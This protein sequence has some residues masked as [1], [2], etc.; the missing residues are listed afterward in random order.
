MH[1]VSSAQIHVHTKQELQL[2]FRESCILSQ[3]LTDEA[4]PVKAELEKSV[5]ALDAV[6]AAVQSLHMYQDAAGQGDVQSH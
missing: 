2:Q 3:D 6:H 1:I 4:R 5:A